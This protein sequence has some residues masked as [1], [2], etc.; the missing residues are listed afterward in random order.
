VPRIV[1]F[2]AVLLASLL[3][4][5]LAV[6]FTPALKVPLA[7]AQ[8]QSATWSGVQALADFTVYRPTALQGLAPAAKNPLDAKFCSPKKSAVRTVYGASELKKDGNP[9]VVILQD[10]AN[11]TCWNPDVKEQEVIGRE[12]VLTK[13]A[14][15]RGG[16]LAKSKKNPFQQ[17]QLSVELPGTGKYEKT[18]T[19]LH[20][21]GFNGVTP[22]Q[23]LSI[24]QSL[25]PV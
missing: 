19:R 13:T 8:A 9:M 15:L 1:K 6:G 12:Q 16:P 3:A 18:K 11:A 4:L 17:V 25:K 7:P 2:R 22:E 10:N 21:T 24:A 5:S 23:L 20:L 14:V